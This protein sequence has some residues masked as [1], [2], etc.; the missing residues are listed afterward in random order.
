MVPSDAVVAYHAKGH[1]G[2]LKTLGE[3]QSGWKVVSSG[4]AAPLN[5]T[6]GP[7]LV[8]DANVGVGEIDIDR[9]K[10]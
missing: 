2:D 7:V 5:A 10:G 8:V 9:P 6:G 1:A 3:E 4:R